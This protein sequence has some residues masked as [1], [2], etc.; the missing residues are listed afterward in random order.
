M[1]RAFFTRVL[2]GAAL[3]ALNACAQL[4]E[5]NHWKSGTMAAMKDPY[6]WVPL[7]AAAL[8]A[9]SGEDKPLSEKAVEDTPV[10]GSNKDS[11]KA[12]DRL[13]DVT[14]LIKNASALMV[15]EDCDSYTHPVQRMLVQQ[16]IVMGSDGVAGEIKDITERKRPYSDGNSFPSQHA[17]KAFSYHAMTR[18]NLLCSKHES[19][20]NNGL[21]WASGVAAA[22]TAYARVEAGAHYPVDVLA[23][24]GLGNFVVMTVNGSLKAKKQDD[25]IIKV[26][27]LPLDDGFAINFS[28]SF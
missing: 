13:R 9:A 27:L 7:G 5:N 16:V 21:L 10:F 3:M 22:G 11:D 12:S 8:L 18:E 15:E 1:R 28:K 17:N 23:G 25:K 26:S 4:P 2:F 24:A 14:S 20:F 19:N 6:T